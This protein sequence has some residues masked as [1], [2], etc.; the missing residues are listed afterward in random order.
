MVNQTLFRPTAKRE[1]EMQE[2]RSRGEEAHKFLSES[3]IF[4]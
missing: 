1:G 4:Y 3:L 2:A